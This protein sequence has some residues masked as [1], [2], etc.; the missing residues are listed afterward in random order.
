MML[1][2]SSGLFVVVFST[3]EE[4]GIAKGG[5]LALVFCLLSAICICGR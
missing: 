3:F 4:N 5:S 1:K 2:F